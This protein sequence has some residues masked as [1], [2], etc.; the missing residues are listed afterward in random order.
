MALGIAI[1][2][3]LTIAVMAKMPEYWPFVQRFSTAMLIS[4]IL[5]GISFFIT[6]ITAHGS[7]L[8]EA[9]GKLK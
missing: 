3:V 6:A 2:I 4:A 9:I 7:I 1:F 5:I 8:S